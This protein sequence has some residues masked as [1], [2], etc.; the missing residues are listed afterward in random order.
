MSDIVRLISTLNYLT[1]LLTFSQAQCVLLSH[2]ID[3]TSHPLIVEMINSLA[4]HESDCWS[5]T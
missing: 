5:Q 1:P 3:L 2:P 4:D